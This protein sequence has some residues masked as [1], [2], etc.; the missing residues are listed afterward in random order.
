MTTSSRTSATVLL[1]APSTRA[2]LPAVVY[3]LA[4]SANWKSIQRFGLLSAS[5]LLK[6]ERLPAKER[7]RL[8]GTCRPNHTRLPGGAEIR[9]QRPM[10]ATALARCLVGMSPAEWYRLVN[11]R[12]FFWVDP[13]RLN[14]QRMACARRPQV[15]LAV[16]VELLLAAH[17]ERIA[18]SPINSGNA[19]R[20]P[21]VRGRSTFVS[22]ASWIES[23]WACEAAGL[24]TKRRSRSHRPAELTVVGAVP[25]VMAMLAGVAHLGPGETFVAE[26]LVPVRRG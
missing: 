16:D 12:V 18:L 26:A 4:E 10:P 3:H 25:G 14:R 8:E 20:R 7:E 9:D 21:A 15:V 23:R 19:R 13:A 6:R 1:P 17:A 24:G 22:Y 2:G 11:A 5:E